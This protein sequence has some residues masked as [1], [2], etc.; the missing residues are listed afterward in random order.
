[1][2]VLCPPFSPTSPGLPDL[3]L[4]ASFPAVQYFLPVASAQSDDSEQ[5][6]RQGRAPSSRQTRYHGDWARPSQDRKQEPSLP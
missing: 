1:M 3:G 6:H 2:A 5:F 4:A